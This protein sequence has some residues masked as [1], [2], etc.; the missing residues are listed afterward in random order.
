MNDERRVPRRRVDPRVSRGGPQR[1]PA[2][3]W[4]PDWG[5]V[6]FQPWV[7]LWPGSGKSKPSDQ[8]VTA[9]LLEP[10]E[11]C[12]VYRPIVVKLADRWT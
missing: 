5:H 4:L 2:V 12:P 9:P 8:L 10:A 3:T 1:A 11:G 6:A 7:I